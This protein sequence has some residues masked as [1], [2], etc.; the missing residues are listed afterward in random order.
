MTHGM[1]RKLLLWYERNKRALPWRDSE[2]PS[3]YRT[4][5]SEIMLQ[6]TR[7]EAVKPYYNRF[8]AALPTIEALANVDDDRLLK[9]WEGLGYYTRA[10]NLKR[11]AQ[12]V[13]REH[14]GVLPSSPEELL[15]LPGIGLYT[16]GAIASIAYGV[17]VPAVDG[18]VLRVCA[19]LAADP[20]DIALDQTKREVSARLLRAMPRDFPGAFNQALMELGA[21][22]CL[23]KTPNCI[24]PPSSEGRQG[25]C[26]PSLEGGCPLSGDCLVRAQ[27]R[28]ADYPVKSP[29]KPRRIEQRHLLI[30]RFEDT[31]AL[32]RRPS[33]GLLAGLWELPA[34]FDIPPGFVLSR[35][36]AGQ[37]IHIFTHIEWHMTAERVTLRGPLPG[38]DLT[39][40]TQEQLRDDYALPSAFAGFRGE[41]F[42]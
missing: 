42:C 8:L 19:R 21:C 7:A 41:M 20:A 5:V 33:K 22:V 3:A 28:T 40:V 35:E 16:A 15:K 27:G 29:Q 39:W 36:P 11:A 4:W 6:Q 12:I 10:R 26:F 32:R 30:L 23:P 9:L 38:E 13:V 25:G 18:N 31:L 24:K 1:I 14:N 2:S 17:P 34:A 37:A